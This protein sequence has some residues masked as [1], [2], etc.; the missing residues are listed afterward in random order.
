ML[1]HA[2]VRAD[3]GSAERGGQQAADGPVV[4]GDEDARR[5]VRQF[6]R[7]GSLSRLRAEHDTDQ[8]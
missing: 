8:S 4:F 6:G 5:L 3:A 7:G 1:L 2:F